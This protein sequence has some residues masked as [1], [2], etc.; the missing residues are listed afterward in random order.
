MD[1]LLAVTAIGPDRTGIVRDLSA[2]ITEA[3]GNI[4]ESRM[5]TLGSEFAVMMLVE[6]NW[7]AINKVQESLTALGE[8]DNLTIN[9]RPTE[10]RGD[11]EVAAPYTVDVIAL[12]QEGIVSGMSG[13][14]A[15]KG[16]EIADVNT[17][18]YNAPHTGAPMFSIQMTINVPRTMHLATL[19]DE[20]HEYCES[21][22][23]DA[24]I[25]PA[26]R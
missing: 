3:G 6:G 1:K 11:S 25:E 8:G 9:V 20:F 15:V 17:R 13:F 12:D 7:H 16:L 26:Q 23:L 5:T 14:F 22:N 4:R 21:E 2:G 24:I 18:R 10:E 19:R